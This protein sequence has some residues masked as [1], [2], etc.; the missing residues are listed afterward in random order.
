MDTRKAQHGS[1][2]IGGFLFYHRPVR[3][4]T[5]EYV[6]MSTLTNSTSLSSRFHG[7]SVMPWPSSSSLTTSMASLCWGTALVL[8][9]AW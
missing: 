8:C 5:L 9:P 4:D 1:S 7:K 2:Q 6:C 3:H